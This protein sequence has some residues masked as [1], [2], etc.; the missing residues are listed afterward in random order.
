MSHD[1]LIEHLEANKLS[2]IGHDDVLKARLKYFFKV[3]R[4]TEAGLG[5]IIFSLPYYIVV[6]F[7]ATCD[8]LNP[9]DFP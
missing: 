7:E 5:Y 1:E 4:F 8:T 2:V 9:P 6:D 3:Q